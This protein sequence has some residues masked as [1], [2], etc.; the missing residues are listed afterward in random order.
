MNIYNISMELLFILAEIEEAQGELTPEMEERLKI[1]NEELEK[2]CKAYYSVIKSKE[3]NTELIKSEIER[4]RG[5]INSN[6][7]VVERLKKV[8]VDTVRLFG[9]DGE[10]GNK[11]LDF[12]TLKLYT[13]D[14]TS[15]EIDENFKDERFIETVT[16]EKINKIK[17][18]EYIKVAGEAPEGVNIIVKTGIR[19]R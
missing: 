13:Q 15:I 7:T 18:K 3:N 2:K 17:I 14:S 12:D 6:N 19:F 16:E 4:L 1:S 9:Y 11:K 5:L 10:K 8:L